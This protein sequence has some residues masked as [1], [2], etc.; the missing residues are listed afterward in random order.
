MKLTTE[1]LKAAKAY[2]KKHG[3]RWRKGGAIVDKRGKTLA[4]GWAKYY[5]EYLTLEIDPTKLNTKFPIR[6]FS[7][8]KVEDSSSIQ[9]ISTP[10]DRGSALYTR[11]KNSKEVEKDSSHKEAIDLLRRVEDYYWEIYR[12]PDKDYAQEELVDIAGDIHRFLRSQ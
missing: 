3:H 2:A 11:I 5:A 8:G 10:T 4:H 12:N 7:V 1:E 9:I 6:E